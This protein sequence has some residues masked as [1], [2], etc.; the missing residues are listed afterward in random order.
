MTDPN[1]DDHLFDII[2]YLV[3]CARL[4]LDEPAIYG[5]FRLI[6]GACRLIDA[7]E[8]LPG[9]EPDDFLRDQ[10]ES[11]D[12]EKSR[13]VDDQAGY[14]AWLTELATRFAS[15]RV[16]RSLAGGD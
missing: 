1:H 16:R 15:E 2:L 11:I 5:S 14:E 3:T 7:V 6:E 4:S 13:T 10:R 8:R 12:R 9:F